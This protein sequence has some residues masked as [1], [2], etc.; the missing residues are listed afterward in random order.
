MIEPSD[1]D[2][3]SCPETVQQYV[4]Q[5]EAEISEAEFICPIMSRNV[6][7]QELTKMGEVSGYTNIKLVKEPCLKKKCAL[8]VV[9]MREGNSKCEH[10]GLMR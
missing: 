10:C 1:S 5:L 9:E 4:K 7:F 6:E 3:N 8:W 2:L